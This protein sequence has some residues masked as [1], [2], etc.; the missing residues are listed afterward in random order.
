MILI[1]GRGQLGSELEKNK[2]KF[3][4]EETVIYHTWDFMD[5]SKEKQRK[6]YLDL[7]DFVDNFDNTKRFVF[8]STKSTNQ[9]FYTKYKRLSERYINDILS[10]FLIINLPNIIG[11]GVCDLFKY[12]KD[13]QAWGKLELITLEKACESII[14]KCNI[15]YPF[16]KTF[17]IDGEIIS[18]QLAKD[19]IR[20]G[21]KE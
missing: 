11:K 18:A 21:A 6:L 19:L 8:I 17:D 15:Q 12:D 9:D 3:L 5:K 20:F 14:D 13:I 10:Y 2:H 4:I 7:V 16:G 1:N